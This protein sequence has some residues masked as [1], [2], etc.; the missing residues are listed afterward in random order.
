[1]K[2]SGSAK[3]VPGWKGAARPI[4]VQLRSAM[5]ADAAA[6]LPLKVNLWPSALEYM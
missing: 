2:R 3:D 1:M 6:L 4:G 5:S